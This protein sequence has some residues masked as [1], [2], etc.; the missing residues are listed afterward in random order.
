MEFQNLGELIREAVSRFPN[1][2]AI[3]RGKEKIT[4]IELEE[5]TNR[6]GNF[7]HQMGAGNG[8][9]PVIFENS[10]ELV[11]AIVGVMKAGGIFAPLDPN[12]PSNRISLMLTEIEA[13]W[14]ITQ[15]EWLQKLDEMLES[16][17]RCLNTLVIDRKEVCKE[18][19]RN[20][21]IYTL[22]DVPL[23]EAKLEEKS[24][25]K[26][27]YIYFTSGSTGKP[28]GILGRQISLAHFIQWEIKEF[29]VNE[30]FRVSQLTSPAFDPFLRDTFVPLCAG[31]TLCIPETR[32]IVMNPK[33]LA[34]WIDEEK[35]HNLRFG[36][37]A[38]ERL[39]ACLQSFV[40]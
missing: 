10:I 9:I 21:K 19:F 38:D 22:D 34:R 39:I 1:K 37:T 26:N 25:N 16:Q 12:F 4:Y 35:I 14:I 11:E 40:S 30:E 32:D 15:G 20:L 27:C 33:S 29:G 2:V 3:E 31:A 8:N 6:L 7:L 36:N 5:K 13:D 24:Q 23:N 18:D 17:S 28:K